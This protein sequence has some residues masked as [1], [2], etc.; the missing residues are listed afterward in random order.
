MVYSLKK[1]AYIKIGENMANNIREIITQAVIAKGKKRTINK[2]PFA[3]G[4]FN[5]VLGCWITNHRYHAAFRDGKPVVLGTFDVHLWYNNND[6]SEILK[7]TVSYLNELDLVKKEERNFDDQDELVVSCNQEPKCVGVEC[8]K[9]K[10]V[11]EIEKEISLS[12]VGKTTIRVETK[13]EQESWDEI[14]N[15][16]LNENFIK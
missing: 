8:Q 4:S 10:I 11:V 12:V 7:Q 16:T 5:K 13:N 2:Y 14:D 9:E 6:D 1:F 15:L 3:I